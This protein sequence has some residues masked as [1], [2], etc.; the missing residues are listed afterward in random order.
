[1]QDRLALLAVQLVG[2]LPEEPVDVSIAAIDVGAAA[3][4]Q[5]LDSGGRVPEG[6]VAALGEA[7]VF[8]FDPPPLERCSLDRPELHTDADGVE[9]VDHRLTHIRQRGIAELVA[10]AEAVA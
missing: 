3:N 4:H 8:L 2:L 10:R 5:R 1:M 7:S 9:L 6:A